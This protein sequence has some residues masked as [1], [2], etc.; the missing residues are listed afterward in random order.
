MLPPPLPFPHLPISLAVCLCLFSTLDLDPDPSSHPLNRCPSLS[1][2]PLAA[3]A[4]LVLDGTTFVLPW[5]LLPTYTGI[6]EVGQLT[7]VPKT[8]L[9][10]CL[11]D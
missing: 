1:L 11:L 9:F 3:P 6:F 2:L 5:L 7:Q 10:V 4:N 8:V